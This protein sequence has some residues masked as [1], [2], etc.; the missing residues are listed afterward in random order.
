MLSPGVREHHDRTVFQEW[1]GNVAGWIESGLQP[2]VFTRSPHDGQAPACARAF[3]ERPRQTAIWFLTE[4]RST[5]SSAGGSLAV[6]DPTS[7]V[8]AAPRENTAV[9]HWLT[10]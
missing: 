10:P 3:H 9:R 7:V 8:S 1:V 4:A 2:F 6:R 5:Q